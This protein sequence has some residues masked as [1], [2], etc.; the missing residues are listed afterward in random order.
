MT[1]FA[2]W[3]SLFHGPCRVR[4]RFRM[5][6]QTPLSKPYNS[7]NLK[8]RVSYLGGFPG[9]CINPSSGFVPNVVDGRSALAN[10]LSRSAGL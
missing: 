5:P 6:N 8:P 7:E 9:L 3:G 10:D 4:I 2:G 1:T